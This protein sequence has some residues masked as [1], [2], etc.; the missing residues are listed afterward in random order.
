MLAIYG[1]AIDGWLDSVRAETVSVSGETALVLVEY[2]ILGVKASE[3]VEM[4]LADG[5][6]VRREV[7]ENAPLRKTADRPSPSRAR[8][9]KRIAGLTRF[10]SGNRCISGERLAFAVAGSGRGRGTG[11]GSGSGT[12]RRPAGTYSTTRAIISS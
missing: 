12:R 7:V 9:R 3:E 4:V 11:S 8:A 5:R 6:W 2:E 1:L 10:G